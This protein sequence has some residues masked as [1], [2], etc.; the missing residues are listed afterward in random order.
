MKILDK[1][2]AKNFL[3]GYA[4]AFGVLI[5]LRI[6]I[7]LFVNLDEF[8]EHSGISSAAILL[9]IISYYGT[10]IAEYFRDFAGMIT[11][12]AAAF[13]LGKMVR[14]NEFVA[15]M[16]SGVSLMRVIMAVIVLAIILTG[17]LIIDQELIIPPLADKLARS[18]DA[19]PGK[20]QY[21]VWF[22]A[23]ENNSLI[24]SSKFD[25]ASATIYNPTIL[26]RQKNKDTN[27]L[28]YETAGWIKAESAVYNFEKKRWDLIKGQFSKIGPESVTQQVDSYKSDIIPRDIPIRRKAENKN[29]L[30]FHQLSILSAQGSK[31]KDI[32]EICSQKHFRVTDPIINLIMLMIGLPIIVCRDPKAMK[33]AILVSFAATTGCFVL[34]FVC[35]I[36]AGE[37]IFWRLMP[38]FWAWLPVFVF[39]PLAIIELDSMKT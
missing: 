39:L 18:Q 33:T 5:G 32:A 21:A 35:K 8:T 24:C 16:A 13:S 14:G 3:V 22:M 23:D 37:N 36:M 9:N 27:S 29:M 7:D 11:V 34:T 31:I 30:S 12:V 17:I 2:I 28:I 1:Y 20:E 15:V 25:V 10:H 4:I 6:I 26:I 19:V 38:E